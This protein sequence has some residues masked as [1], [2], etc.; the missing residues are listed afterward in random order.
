MRRTVTLDHDVVIA[1][2]RLR[3]ERKISLSEALN[4]VVRAAMQTL[5]PR[6]P[7][8]QRSADLGVGIDIRNVAEALEFAEGP[9]NRGC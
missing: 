8:R 3:R 5:H 4:E 7:F 2:E 9:S 6:M 1:L